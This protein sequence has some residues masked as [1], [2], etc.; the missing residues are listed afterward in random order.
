MALTEIRLGIYR[1][2]KRCAR[3][4]VKPA[5]FVVQG[6]AP[7]VDPNNVKRVVG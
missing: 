5:V 6:M 1:G 7:K 2:E 3:C 4:E